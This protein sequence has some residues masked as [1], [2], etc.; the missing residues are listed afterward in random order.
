MGHPGLSDFRLEMVVKWLPELPP[1][2]FRVGKK[3]DITISDMGKVYLE[4]DSQITL[5]TEDGKEYDVAR[6][7]WGFYATP[8]LNGRLK[9]FNLRGSLVKNSQGKYYVFLVEQEKEKDF[10][11]YLDQDE[12][13]FVCWLD[14][15]NVLNKIDQLES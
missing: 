10:R 14:D 13:K 12:L 4:P 9:R 5:M 8:S 3:S 2:Q 7:S 1:R 11:N 15:E 6:K